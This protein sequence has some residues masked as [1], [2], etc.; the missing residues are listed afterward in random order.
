[1]LFFPHRQDERLAKIFIEKKKNELYEK[2]LK[3]RR[4]LPAWQ[5]MLEVL[6]TVKNFQVVVICGETGCG[7]STQVSVVESKNIQ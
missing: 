5:K 2:S 3:G 1:M 6:D 4:L 7:K